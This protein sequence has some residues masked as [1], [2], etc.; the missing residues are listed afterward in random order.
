MPWVKRFNWVELYSLSSLLETLHNAKSGSQKGREG[1]LERN[2]EAI[3]GIER[4]QVALMEK[5]LVVVE[6]AFPDNSLIVGIDFGNH[7][8]HENGST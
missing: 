4:V 3:L 1:V 8:V 2:Q 5:V 6:S 7:H